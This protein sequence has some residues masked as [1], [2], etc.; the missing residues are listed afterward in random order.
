MGVWK[1]GMLHCFSCCLE[2]GLLHLLFPPLPL[3]ASCEGHGWCVLVC[4]A[5]PAPCERAIEPLGRAARVH[6]TSLSAGRTN[7][8]P[9]NASHGIITNT[10][11]H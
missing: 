3:L 1:E 8:A 11:C 7:T 6:P 5:V 9:L 4:T 2:G 10:L